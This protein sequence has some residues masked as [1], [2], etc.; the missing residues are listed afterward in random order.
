MKEEIYNYL[1]DNKMP[2][3]IKEPAIKYC[4]ECSKVWE[5]VY[6]PGKKR[7]IMHYPGLSSYKLTRKVCL[8]CNE[9]K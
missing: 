3:S 9:D 8:N 4:T 1:K 2:A 5:I 7:N 6:N